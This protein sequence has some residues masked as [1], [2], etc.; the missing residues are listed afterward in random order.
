M[1]LT[2]K[3]DAILSNAPVFVDVLEKCG[4]QQLDEELFFEF[5]VLV[6]QLI[7]YGL[8]PNVGHFAFSIAELLFT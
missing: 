4:Q 5:C 7:Y 6:D 2:L 8:S 1:S 3:Q